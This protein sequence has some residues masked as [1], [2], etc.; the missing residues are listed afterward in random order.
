MQ[1]SVRARPGE[2]REVALEPGFPV[3][4]ADAAGLR[5]FGT[6]DQPVIQ[7][8]QPTGEDDA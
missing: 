5:P 6:I 4:D 1:D 2:P 3:E 8:H 7:A